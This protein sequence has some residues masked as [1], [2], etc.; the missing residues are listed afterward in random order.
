MEPI[1]KLRERVLSVLRWPGP[2]SKWIDP[3]AHVPE[4]LDRVPLDGPLVPRLEAATEAA[5]LFRAS[6]FVRN[7]DPGDCTF[8]EEL[9]WAVYKRLAVRLMFNA[10]YSHEPAK[11][12]RVT[13]LELAT[14]PESLR[15]RLT[16]DWRRPWLATHLRQLAPKY[17][18]LCEHPD[19]KQHVPLR[20]WY[21]GFL[22]TFAKKTFPKKLLDVFTASMRA[23]RD[24]SSPRSSK[25][26]ATTH[27]LPSGGTVDSHRRHYR[28]RFELFLV[29]VVVG[30]APP[31]IAL[32]MGISER[33]MVTLLSEYKIR[34]ADWAK[35]SD[36]LD[37]YRHVYGFTTSASSDRGDGAG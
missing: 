30:R 12:L 7:C 8:L 1:D 32:A 27:G 2:H 10:S 6:Q 11:L 33:A 13:W 16:E 17:A 4:V 23:A 22:C 28:R 34:C 25:A 9:R 5:V 3:Q 37:A 29:R 14:D 36:W 19:H 15:A 20:N 21:R 35:E 26:I 18:V 24:Y 31:N